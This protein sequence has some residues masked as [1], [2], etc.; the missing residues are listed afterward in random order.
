MRPTLKATY[1]L[2][3]MEDFQGGPADGLHV[4]AGGLDLV[5]IDRESDQG[6]YDETNL[7]MRHPVRATS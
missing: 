2:T 5:E 1:P 3:S 6:V 4:V 7:W